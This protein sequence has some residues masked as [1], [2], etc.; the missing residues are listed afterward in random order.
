MEKPHS[1]G[2]DNRAFRLTILSWM[3]LSTFVT[4]LLVDLLKKVLVDALKSSDF[5][6]FSSFDFSSLETSLPL[7]SVLLS[8][9]LVPV[10][11][12]IIYWVYA[13]FI[14]KINRLDKVPNLSGTWIGMAHNH[15]RVESIRLELMQIEQDWQQILITV[16]V[17][18]QNQENPKEVSS[19]LDEDNSSDE[20]KKTLMSQI[21]SRIFGARTNKDTNKQPV[22]KVERMGT[23][24]STIALITERVG[25]YSDFTFTYNH[26]GTVKRQGVFKGA[27]FLKYQ[28][29]GK[30]HVLEG[31][32]INDKQGAN[33]DGLVG[34]IV[35][36]RVSPQ[37]I[38]TVEA[39]QKV[40]GKNVLAELH[41]VVMAELNEA[42]K[43]NL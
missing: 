34:K 7:L 3:A 30:F 25:N 36:H 14:W 41:R 10:T 42:Q 9:G 26:H 4:V 11:F 35:F 12:S 16:E 22:L 5:S 20:T 27:M 33:F 8:V 15:L 39:L 40:K 21:M 31:D 28:E 37:I 19:W 18:P 24:R 17:Y 29:R 43:P 6:S 2:V 32:Y 23:E 38:E 13:Q 1:Y